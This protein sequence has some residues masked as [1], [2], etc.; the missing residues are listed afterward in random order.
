MPT[1]TNESGIP[2]G[3]AGERLMTQGMNRSEALDVCLVSKQAYVC[4]DDAVTPS[5]AADVFCRIANVS[6]SDPLVITKIVAEAASAELISVQTTA[7]YT[8]ATS[9]AD[10]VAAPRYAGSTNTFINKGCTFESDVDITGDSGSIE[11][12]RIGLGVAADKRELDLTGSEIV[13][14]VGYSLLLE[15]VTGGVALTYSVFCH[16]DVAST[17]NS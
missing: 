11:V 17:I 15:A 3:V 13:I 2:A 12:A 5:A 7:N 8:S 6:S 16:F 9:H 4:A 10:K 14:P 1:V